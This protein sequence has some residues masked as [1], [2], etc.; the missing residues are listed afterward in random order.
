[1]ILSSVSGNELRVQCQ[2]SGQCPGGSTSVDDTITMPSS[3]NT[4]IEFMG[5]LISVSL[6]QDSRTIEF[7]N[8]SFSECSEIAT[9]DGS[10]SIGTTNLASIFILTGLSSV[11]QFIG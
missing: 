8:P 10:S 4:Q 7:I 1:M 9:R 6:S 11:R 3:Y 5:N 2:F